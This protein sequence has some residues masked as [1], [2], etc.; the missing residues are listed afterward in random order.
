MPAKSKFS[1]WCVAAALLLLGLLGGLLLAGKLD[2]KPQSF[3]KTSSKPKSVTIVATGDISCAPDMPKSTFDCRSDDT[4]TLITSLNPQAVLITGDI[5]YQ[6]GTL[7]A[8]QAAYDKTWGVFKDKS[9]PVPGNHEYETEGAA[10]Y[11]DYFGE[12]AGE[13]GKGYYSFNIGDWLVLA[14][15]SEID[16]SAGSPQY[17]WAEQQLKDKKNT[18]TLAF[19]HKPRF[20]TGG[21]SDDVAYDAL[22]RLLYSYDAELILNGHSHGYERYVPQNPDGASDPDKGIVEI[23]SGLGG[24]SSHRMKDPV[25]TLATR[26]SHAFGVLKLD[27]FPKAAHY[28][29]VPIPGE[30]T[31]MDS[32]TITCH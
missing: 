17:A 5:Q 27:L 9:Y 4:A 24:R 23:V 11:Y 32:G 1:L 30:Q 13:R 18:C 14:L 10:G 2:T 31:F 26:Q 8:F 25:K 29:F 6:K 21:H 15:N 20:S 3:T 16:V 22:W 7:E 19:W 28:E 12:R